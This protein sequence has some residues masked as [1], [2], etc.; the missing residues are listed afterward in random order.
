[1]SK[2]ES[3]IS[4]EKHFDSLINLTKIHIPASTLEHSPILLQMRKEDA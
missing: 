2:L 4:G 1:M 3:G